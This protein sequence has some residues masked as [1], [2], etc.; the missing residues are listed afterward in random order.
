MGS[1]GTYVKALAVVEPLWKTLDIRAT[2]GAIPPQ[3][4]LAVLHLVACK[5]SPNRCACISVLVLVLQAL[6]LVHT[7]EI[8]ASE[9]FIDKKNHI[10]R[11]YFRGIDIKHVQWR[12]EDALLPSSLDFSLSVEANSALFSMFNYVE[13]KEDADEECGQTQA[14][15]GEVV[16]VL[17][18]KLCR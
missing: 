8:H 11:G 6:H 3:D 16:Q 13:N 18:K 15:Q 12:G 5:Y 1:C 7:A 10:V 9:I 2:P 17:L 14:Q 4:K